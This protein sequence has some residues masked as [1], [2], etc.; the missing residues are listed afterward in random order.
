MLYIMGIYLFYSNHFLKC[1]AEGS[2]ILAQELMKFAKLVEG[3]ACTSPSV[4]SSELKREEE[5]GR[6]QPWSIS[7][8]TCPFSSSAGD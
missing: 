1:S 8:D 6:T 5:K 2:T 7:I 4:W 3:V